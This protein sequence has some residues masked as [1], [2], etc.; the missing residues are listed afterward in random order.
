[1]VLGAIGMLGK[2]DEDRLKEDG[3]QVRVMVRD[4]DKVQGKFDESIEIFAGNVTYKEAFAQ[5]MSDC[6]GVHICVEEIEW[7]ELKGRLSGWLSSG[8]LEAE[9]YQELDEI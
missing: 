2:S 8:S 1:M 7:I 6:M 4:G 9:R 3:F 5:S